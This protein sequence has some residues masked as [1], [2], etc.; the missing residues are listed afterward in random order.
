MVLP[1]PQLLLPSPTYDTIYNDI[2]AVRLAA[3]LPTVLKVI[4]ETSKLDRRAIVAGALIAK[5]AG[6]DFVKTSTGFVEGGATEEAVRVMKAV[7]GEGVGVK[8]S[9]GVRTAEA[10]RKM[11][12]AGAGR[13]G[14][15][16]GVGIM[17]KG[18]EGKGVSGAGY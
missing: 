10:V 5:E 7:V 3:P 2:R 13:V 11:V 9:G 6:A 4:L 14:T 1:W 15:S 18:V 17:E 16:G 8:A 12:E